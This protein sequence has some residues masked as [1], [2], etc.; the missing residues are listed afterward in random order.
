MHVPGPFIDSKPTSLVQVYLHAVD[1][2]P[3]RQRPPS[4]QEQLTDQLTKAGLPKDVQVSIVSTVGAF[5]S[6]AAQPAHIDSNLVLTEDE[7]KAIGRP[8]VGQTLVL[9]VDVYA[10]ENL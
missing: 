7:Y 2:T 3:E 1:L 10:E 6:M 4:L 8:S 5:S 9:N